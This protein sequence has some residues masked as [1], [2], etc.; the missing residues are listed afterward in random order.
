MVLALQAG[1][2]SQGLLNAI[3]A[4]DGL[5]VC[6]VLEVRVYPHLASSVPQGS[7]DSIHS[8]IGFP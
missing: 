5:S 8:R 3:T 4:V 6:C 2:M 7:E 1:L